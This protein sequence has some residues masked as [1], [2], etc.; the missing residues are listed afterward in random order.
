MSAAAIVPSRLWVVVHA[1]AASSVLVMDASTI[2][3]EETELLSKCDAPIESTA[4]SAP[5]I[6]PSMIAELLTEL[7]ARF[8]ELIALVPMSAPTIVPS[9]I[10][11]LVT[12]LLAIESS[13][14]LPTTVP[15]R[16]PPDAATPLPSAAHDATPAAVKPAKKV[17]AAQPA[18]SGN[19]TALHVR[20]PVLAVI[21]VTAWFALHASTEPFGRYFASSDVWTVLLSPSA[22]SATAAR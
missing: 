13:T 6:V 2:S 16:P 19:C 7:A 12:P 18:P 14:S 22:L 5:V 8:S 17:P 15:A 9:R 4:R 1:P 3:A 10:L 20:F 21:D 11:A